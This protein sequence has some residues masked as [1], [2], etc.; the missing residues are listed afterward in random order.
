MYAPVKNHRHR[1]CFIQC[2]GDLAA[3]IR[4]EHARRRAVKI[5]RP[6]QSAA[7]VHLG[8]LAGVKE[9]T[10]LRGRDPRFPRRVFLSGSL[11]SAAGAL[12][13]GTGVR[14]SYPEALPG[15][16]GTRTVFQTHG[17]HAAPDR[18]GG[19][20]IDLQIDDMKTLAATSVT[21]I[22]PTEEYAGKAVDARLLVVARLHFDNVDEI[23]SVTERQLAIH[24]GLQTPIFQVGNEIDQ[25]KFGGSIISPERFNRDVFIPVINATRDSGAKILIPPMGPGSP[26]EDGY[27]DRLLRDIKVTLPPDIIRESLGVCIHNYFSQGQDPL[28]RVRR[29]YRQVT[30]ILGQMPIYIGEAGLNQNRMHFYPD[31]VIRDETLRYLQMPLSDLP[32]LV[33]NWWLIGNRV[34]RGPPLPEHADVFEDFETSAWRKEAGKTTPVY[35]AVAKLAQPIRKERRGMLGIIEKY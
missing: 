24:R 4:Q 18:G 16:G 35:D 14:G 26:T 13:G 11:A 7:C 22:L 25:E 33:N 5:L 8:G 9:S 19:Q 21:V 20:R 6:L 30:N 32:V 28:E 17:F 3:S 31:A 15:N 2:W 34:F 12:I 1:D 27:L 10:G 23:P 29:I